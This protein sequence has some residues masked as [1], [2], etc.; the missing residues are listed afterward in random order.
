MT[1]TPA[2]KA[3]RGG[4]LDALRFIAAAFIVLYHYG[5][6]AP[7]QLDQVSGFFGRGWLATNFFLMLS[8]YI[9][10][11][12]Y[13]GSLDE[14]RVGAVGFFRRRLLRVWPGQVIVLVGFATVLFVT[15]AIGIAPRFPENFTAEEFLAQATLTHAWGF[16][17]TLGWNQ[18]SWSLSVLVVCYALFPLIWRATRRIPPMVALAAGPVLIAVSAVAV[19]AALGA[20]IYDL[21]FTFGL[22][23]GLPMFFCGVLMA[24]AAAGLDM[25]STSARNLF[26]AAVAVF[27]LVQFAPRTELT[28]FAVMLTIAT[29]ILSADAWK[30]A[31]SRLA[32][33]GARLSFSVYIASALA[34]SIYFGLARL[35]VER[36]ELAEPAQ[37]ALWFAA[38]PFTLVF[39]WCYERAVDAPLLAWVKSLTAR[40]APRPAPAPSV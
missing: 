6:D 34:G 26:F 5:Y 17:E 7:V 20:S 11:R 31:T 39:A 24:R 13:G 1:P 12:A 8:G 19:Q 29:V 37:W 21:R 10:G 33:I 3:E 18:P 30:G 40:P 4:A 9:L 32:A 16:R 15:G 36:F 28:A 22:A 14:G 2:P 25:Q 27:G 38:F 23:R 35:A